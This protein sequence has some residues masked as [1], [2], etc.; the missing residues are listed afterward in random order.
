[1]TEAQ[2]KA[3]QQAAARAAAYLNS[4]RSFAIKYGRQLKAK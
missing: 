2:L 1:M 3:H 4:S